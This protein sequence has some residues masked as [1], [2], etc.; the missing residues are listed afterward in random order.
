MKVQYDK[1]N[2]IHYRSF[3]DGMIVRIADEISHEEHLKA[4]QLIKETRN[5][6]KLEEYFDELEERLYELDREK[7]KE[8][9]RKELA[10]T[11]TTIE[12]NNKEV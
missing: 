8:Y 6:D 7:W 2:K 4:E 10:D 12:K 1:R 3:L 11:L 9:I 5:V